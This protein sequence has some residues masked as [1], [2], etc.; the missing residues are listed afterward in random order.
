MLG[1]CALHLLAQAVTEYYDLGRWSATMCCDNKQALL[2]SSH[3]KGRIQPSAKCADIQRSFRATK[4]TYR[5]G[6]KYVHVYGHMDQHLSWM[7]LSLMQQLNCVYN[8]LAKKA[9]TTAIINGYH[10]GQAQILPKEDVVLIVWGNKI[11]GNISGPLC[12]HASEAVACKYHTHQRKK[13]KCTH[14]KFKE[15]NWEHL[16]LALKSKADNYKIWQSKQ[17]S[18]FCGT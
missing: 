11:T 1:L 18:R 12:F 17:T 4:Q 3:H 15:V 13:G 6:F 7:Q 8:T 2:L 16:D 10:K 9:V 5:G 14:E